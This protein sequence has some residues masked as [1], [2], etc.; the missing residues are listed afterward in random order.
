MNPSHLLS[1]AKFSQCYGMLCTCGLE[2]A[3]ESVFIFLTGIEVWPTGN[4]K[5]VFGFAA[6]ITGIVIPLA[7]FTFL[8]WLGILVLLNGFWECQYMDLF[9][10]CSGQT[11]GYLS[12]NFTRL[13]Y[14][15]MIISSC[16]PQWDKNWEV[17]FACPSLFSCFSLYTFLSAYCWY[18]PPLFFFLVVNR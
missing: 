13:H 7:L 10:P 16:T 9:S 12:I 14:T 3:Y 8:L 4:T 15:N 17:L 5:T 6:F 1:T 18:S 2:Q 11:G